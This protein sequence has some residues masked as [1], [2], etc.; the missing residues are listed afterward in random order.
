MK[1]FEPYQALC[2]GEDGLDFYRAV[3]RDWGAALAP[4]GRLLFEVGIGQAEAVLALMEQAGFEELCTL[5]DDQGIQRVAA[6][7]W[8]KDS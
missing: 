6:G 7:I 1:D 4:G 2:G 5:P 3:T 8:K